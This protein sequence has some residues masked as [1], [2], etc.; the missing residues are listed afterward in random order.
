MAPRTSKKGSNWRPP[1]P[2]QL[3][4][5]ILSDSDSDSVVVI[6]D[7]SVEHDW[8]DLNFD[9]ELLDPETVPLPE[10][11]TDPE[12]VLLPELETDPE[13]VLL[14]ELE[15]DPEIFLLPEPET[16]PE[17]APLHEAEANTEQTSS[18]SVPESDKRRVIRSEIHVIT[19]PP[20]RH[21]EDEPGPSGVLF[22]GAEGRTVKPAVVPEWRTMPG[23][24][25]LP[26]STYDHIAERSAW[27]IN[28]IAV[29]FTGITREELKHY[30]TMVRSWQ[31]EVFVQIER[32]H[33]RRGT[34]VTER[35]RYNA[36]AFFGPILD[37]LRELEEDLSLLPHAMYRIK[38]NYVIELLE[39]LFKLDD[40]SLY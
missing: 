18:K 29:R 28:R 10:P 35:Q 3:L 24:V 9:Q 26:R 37:F 11:E 13:I 7:E 2:P 6:Q 15:T 32:R 38:L 21:R 31:T 23:P 34:S 36:K 22:R 8:M 33:G 39:K 4:S 27:L 20:K 5:D 14:P 12:I 19:P 25:L 30:H 16:D 17:T 40:D 1:T